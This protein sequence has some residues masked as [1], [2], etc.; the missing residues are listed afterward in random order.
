MTSSAISTPSANNKSG[1]EPPTDLTYA[2][3][4]GCQEVYES[5]PLE[6]LSA[7]LRFFKIIFKKACQNI[8]YY[9]NRVL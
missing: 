2:I 4:H 1:Y 7:I 9:F 3:Y 8:Y 6:A 5:E